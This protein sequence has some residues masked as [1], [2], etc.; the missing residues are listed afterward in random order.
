MTKKRRSF[1]KGIK[2][3]PD[4]SAVTEEGEVKY[5]DTGKKIQ[6][7]DDSTTR[8]VVSEDGTQTLEN[9]TI[10]ATSATGNNTLSADS[11]DIVYDNSTSG[12]TAT[13]VKSAIDELDTRLESQDEASEI[14]YDNST[15][16][17]TA[18]DVQ[19][20]IDETEGRVDTLEGATHVNSFNSRTGVVVPATSDYDA[21]QVDYD[22][23]ASGLTATNVKTAIDEL[24]TITD[25]QD[26]A[27]EITYDNT[28]SGLTAIDVQAAVD[29]VEGRLDTAE[30]SLSTHTGASTGVHGVTGD[31]VG[32]T[33]TQT[34]TNKT[35]TGADFRTPSRS[36]VKQDTYANLV[37][38]ASF[39]SNGQIVFA[40]DTKQMFQVVD[41]AL[42]SIGGGGGGLDNWLVEDFETTVAADFSTGN[43]A[44]FEGGGTLD[45]VLSD[46]TTNPLSGDS[47]LKYVAGA[48]SLNDYFASPVIDVDF[49]QQDNDSGFTFYFTWDGTTAIEAVVWDETNSSKLN[50]VLDIIGTADNATRYSATFYPSSTCTQV[51]YGFHILE[52][53]TNG[54]ILIVD[55]VEFSTN[56]FAYKNLIDEQFLEYIAPA[57]TFQNRV[58][59]LRFPVGF[60]STNLNGESILKVEDDVAN[61]RTKFT[62]LRKCSVDITWTGRMSAATF[63]TIF[64]NGVRVIRGTDAYTASASAMCSANIQLE[65]DDYI[66]LECSALEN[67]SADVYATIHAQAT[68]EHVVTPVKSNMTD[69][70]AYTPTFQGFGTP[71]NLDIRWRRVGDSMEIQGSFDA[72][73][74]TASEA[75]IGLPNSL[76][77]SSALTQIK[78]AGLISRGAAGNSLNKVALLTASDTFFN[79]GNGLGGSGSEVP[80]GGTSVVNSGEGVN[81]FVTVPIEGWSSDAQFLVASPIQKVAY[82]KDVKSSGVGGGTFT[83]GAWQTRDLNNL[84]GDN[85]LSV[86]SNQFTLTPGKYDV[87]I[88]APAYEVNFHQARLQNITDA[89]RQILGSVSYSESGASGNVSNISR[90]VGSFELS[91]Q[92]VFEVQHRCTTSGTF[93]NAGSI[94]DEIYTQVKITK[95]R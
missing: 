53:P 28:T 11:D 65:V 16:G 22:N 9:K 78:M 33:D 92:K 57:N 49:K 38:Y 34:L 62:A 37:T 41:S 48:S 80:I 20:A 42:I 25:G 39:E 15:S 18:T 17:L 74:V 87:E 30:G 64:K 4:T 81:F 40:T 69:W 24:K 27:S 75:Q 51:R 32:T 72:G 52:A 35:I 86:S 45:G 7:R 63:A 93:G 66:T 79:I 94:A 73:T 90:I 55:D 54:D 43:S 83:S 85:F 3:R 8:N 12:L 46:E 82:V 89:I 47:S 44:T 13:D 26:E 91:S 31:V 84:S 61:T 29:E 56:P 58:G 36:D 88:T 10:D 68:T 19:A 23:G 5:D 59:E 21:V 70:I 2:L 60:D 1:D 77:V 95:L 67:V 76:S 14:T 71:T 6:Y 50:S